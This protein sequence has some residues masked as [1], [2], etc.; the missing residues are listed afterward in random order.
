MLLV[1]RVKD[2]YPTG[3]HIESDLPNQV[4]VTCSDLSQL[5]D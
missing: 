2:T 4:A 5:I 1:D 3:W